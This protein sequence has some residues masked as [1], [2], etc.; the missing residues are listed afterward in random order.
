M[1]EV[2]DK[3]IKTEKY[4]QVINDAEKSGRRERITTHLWTIYEGI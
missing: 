1:K 3:R 4:V 2:G